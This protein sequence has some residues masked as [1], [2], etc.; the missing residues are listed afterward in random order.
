MNE[1]DEIRRLLPEQAPPADR[2]VAEVRAQLVGEPKP[3]S[4][5]SRVLVPLAAAVAVAAAASAVM[6]LPGNDSV[7]TNEQAAGPT[8]RDILLVAADQADAQGAETGRYWRTRV[9]GGSDA[10]DDPKNPEKGLVTETWLSGDGREPAWQGQRHLGMNP[11]DAGQVHELPKKSLLLPGI[12]LQ[13]GDL[14]TESA[15]LRTF[16]LG[17]WQQPS[18]DPRLV[19]EY[20]FTSA[21]KL[22]AEVPATPETRAAALRLI[23]DLGAVENAGQVTDPLG[24]KGNGVTLT[25]RSKSIDVTVEL[26]IDPENGMVLSVRYSGS[27]KGAQVKAP[28]FFAVLSTGW[29]DEAPSV[30]S[31]DVP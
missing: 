28:Y 30:P 26:V 17:Y 11:P 25:Q 21:V 27:R 22:L 24:R 10:G 18:D 6:V 16:L 2:L 3:V 9:L 13:V 31:A 19:D 14:P 15:A 4:R 12:D 20:L 8:D 7:P 1:I 29:T 5:R 23:A